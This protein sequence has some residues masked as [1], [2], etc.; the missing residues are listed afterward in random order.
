MSFVLFLITLILIG[1]I[2]ILIVFNRVIKQK[3]SEIER[4]NKN[5]K[6]RIST[7]RDF[8][9]IA[10]E[11][12]SVDEKL[13]KINEIVM[14]TYD[15]K[16]STIVVFDGAEYVI[17]TSNVDPKHYDVLT[18]LHNEEIFQDSVASATPKYVT[19]D[20]ENELIEGQIREIKKLN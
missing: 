6:K 18:N 3:L 8:L 4:I 14:E 11:E 5:V 13:R 17:K 7:V 12:I 15:I 20:N 2:V 19:I 1:L 9:K 16:Y 10:G